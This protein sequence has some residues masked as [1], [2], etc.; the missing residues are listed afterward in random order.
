M[1]KRIL[2]LLF[3]V[4]IIL[5]IVLA[6]SSYRRKFKI[7][8][9]DVG[10][11]DAIYVRT[12]ENYDILIDG[13]P[14]DTVLSKLGEAMPFYDREIDIVIVSHPHADHITG[15][16]SVL[17]NYKVKNV[18]LSGASHTTYEY[19]ELLRQLAKHP[20]TRKVKVD[21]PI[22]LR[23]GDETALFFLYPDF[24]VADTSAP[25]FTNSNLNNT[26]VVV[27]LTH[28]GK[29]VLFTGDIE[30]EAEEYMLSKGIDVS[31]D[32][33]KVAHQGSRTSSTETFLRAVY[34]RFA[35]IS[36]GKNVYG[37]PHP[38]TLDRLHFLNI[39][40][41]RT[42]EEGDIVFVF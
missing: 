30:K 17:Q 20:E 14:D 9:F 24:D 16:L 7:H 21:H 18:Y 1:F 11:G 2:F 34:P 6:V 32:V 13:G 12:V 27:K 4:N 26:S 37:H 8:F 36:V 22:T 3:A 5:I 19:L 35:V 39:R 28:K 10:Q 41:L 25:Q 23:L 33:L 29:S 40:P 15:L 42:D 38:D 31:G